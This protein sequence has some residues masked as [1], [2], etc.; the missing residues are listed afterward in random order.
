MTA[1]IFCLFVHLFMEEWIFH[2]ILISSSWTYKNRIRQPI[3]DVKTHHLQYHAYP[4]NT[5]PEYPLS[6]IDNNHH[7]FRIYLHHALFPPPWQRSDGCLLP[8]PCVLRRIQHDR[9]R[10]IWTSRSEKD[11]RRK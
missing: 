6:S 7:L 4:G 1:H 11:I 8:F 10:R 9:G 2:S 3:S 5:A